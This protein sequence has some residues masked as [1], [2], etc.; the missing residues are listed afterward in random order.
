MGANTAMTNL[1]SFVES[2]NS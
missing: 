2:E 1:E